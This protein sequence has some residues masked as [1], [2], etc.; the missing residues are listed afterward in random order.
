MNK[1]IG[2]SLGL[3]CGLPLLLVLAG[4]GAVGYWSQPAA[5][6]CLSVIAL[7]GG[8]VGW[9]YFTRR[10]EADGWDSE[11]GEPTFED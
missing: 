3:C 9:A 10:G 5:M 6:G 8:F 11:P 2:W 4:G 1:L 7:L